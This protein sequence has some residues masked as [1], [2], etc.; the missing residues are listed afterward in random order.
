[1][2]TTT[3]R[4]AISAV[5]LALGACGHR[6]AAPCAT[7]AAELRSY[8]TAIFDS[9]AKPRP[10]WPT[11]NADTDAIVDKAR[12]ELRAVTRE[13]SADKAR[14]LVAATRGPVDDTLAGCPQAS[15]AYASLGSREGSDRFASY[16]I[17]IGDGV[18][19]CSCHVDIPLVESALYLLVRGPD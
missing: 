1:M 12:A 10:P 6:D 9:T 16:A 13:T 17:A 3:R 15:D 11:G 8:V 19:A 14:P 2:P 18:E 5:F 4:S 7:R